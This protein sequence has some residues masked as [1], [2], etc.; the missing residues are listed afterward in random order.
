MPGAPGQAG[1][2]RGVPEVCGAVFAWCRGVIVCGP[3]NLGKAGS[4][5]ESCVPAV[6]IVNLFRPWDL[7]KAGSRSES[8][9]PA[10][11]IVWCCLVILFRPLNLGKAGSRSESCVPAVV[12]VWCCL[13]LLFRSLDFGGAGGFSGPVTRGSGSC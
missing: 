6:V 12:I 5:S 11:L 4:R 2:V 10:V 8:C 7:G 3:L 13:V 1:N 9:V